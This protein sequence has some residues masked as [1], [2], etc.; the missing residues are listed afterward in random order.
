MRIKF[1]DG[2]LEVNPAFILSVQRGD[3]YY[4]T[5]ALIAQG[6]PVVLPVEDPDEKERLNKLIESW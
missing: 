3:V 1:Q 2:T 5:L 6:E 4:V